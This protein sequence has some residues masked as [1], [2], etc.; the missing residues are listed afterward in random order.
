LK[1]RDRE[2]ERDLN[3]SKIVNAQSGENPTALERRASKQGQKSLTDG[4]RTIAA[5]KS[6]SMKHTKQPG[7]R[8]RREWKMTQQDQ[9]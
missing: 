5:K 1:K 7:E 3:E 9:P 2:K 6:R 8:K 4:K